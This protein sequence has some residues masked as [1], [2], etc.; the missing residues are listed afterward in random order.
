MSSHFSPGRETIRRRLPLFF[1]AF[2]L[3]YFIPK[4]PEKWAATVAERLVYSPPTK[5]NRQVAIVPDDA[6]GRR[7]FSGISRFPRPCIPTLLHTHLA[8]PSSAL[9]TSTLR[10]AQIS[11]LDSCFFT[12]YRHILKF[13]P[14]KREIRSHV[15]RL[16]LFYCVR[17]L[18]RKR[19]AGS[20][21]VTS[22]DSPGLTAPDDVICTLQGADYRRIARA[23]FTVVR[24]P[25]QPRLLTVTVVVRRLSSRAESH[26]ATVLRSTRGAQEHPCLKYG[27]PR[28]EYAEFTGLRSWLLD[29]LLREVEAR[30]C[31]TGRQQRECFPPQCSHHCEQPLPI[32]CPHFGRVT[33]CRQ[34]EGWQ[35]SRSKMGSPP[36]FSHAGIVLDEA[37]GQRVFSGISRFHHPCIPALLHT[38]IASPSSALDA[39][40]LRA[41]RTSPTQ[42]TSRHRRCNSHYP[43]NSSRTRRQNGIT[44]QQHVTPFA[45]S[46]PGDLLCQPVV[47]Q[48]IG[49]SKSSCL[50]AAA[51]TLR[52]ACQIIRG[53]VTGNSID[54]QCLK[55]RLA[56]RQVREIS[57]TITAPR[58]SS[59]RGG[60]P[61]SQISFFLYNTCG[62]E[63]A[64]WYVPLTQPFMSHKGNSTDAV[65][66]NGGSQV[67]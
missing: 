43:A 58:G 11:P 21:C 16:R 9:R 63:V 32:F 33:M 31:G 24:P 38:H 61:Q 7:V 41:A 50:L 45:Q 10:A 65:D 15:A 56:L 48:P 62:L 47:A 22:T 12:F 59:R 1:Y 51:N 36:G 52:A 53:L 57:V 67:A 46:A 3:L 17:A 35:K 29:N 14:G 54:V 40:M 4:P 44:S 30:N 8:S 6:A 19:R 18:T 23:S 2:L 25:P 13:F 34:H 5:V 64:K 66:R 20:Q 37:A 26:K 42:T 28:D 27:L 49:R 55:S 60:T 39:P